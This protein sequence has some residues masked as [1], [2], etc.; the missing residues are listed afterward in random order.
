VVNELAEAARTISPALLSTEA[1]VRR[2]SA[3]IFDRFVTESDVAAV[4]FVAP[5][6]E[7]SMAQ[8]IDFAAAWADHPHARFGYVDAFQDVSLARVLE[9]RRLPTILVLRGGEEVSRLEGRQSA[10]SIACALKG[11]AR[12]SHQRADE[13][14]RQEYPAHRQAIY[15]ATAC[16]GDCQ[17]P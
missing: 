11:A 1:I 8:A 4:L 15:A 10:L 5:C 12:A 13:R 2:L 7:A 6:G 3:K 9:I 17:G 16:P 14:K